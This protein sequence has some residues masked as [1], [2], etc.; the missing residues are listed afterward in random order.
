MEPLEQGVHHIV[1]LEGFAER[2]DGTGI[3]HVAREFK[4]E[5]THEGK[6][7]GDLELQAFDGKVVQALQDE[8]LE[9]EHAAG[10]L[11]PGSALALLGVD[12]LKD[13]AEDFPVDDGIEPFQGIRAATCPMNHIQRCLF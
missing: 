7:I 9:H 4:T 10:G 12:A 1:G 2:P 11:V 5:E 8:Q 13:G 6:L 3:G